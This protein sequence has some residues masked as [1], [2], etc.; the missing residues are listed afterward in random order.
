MKRDIKYLLV[1]LVLFVLTFYF[2]REYPHISKAEIGNIS[3]FKVM[4]DGNIIVSEEGKSYIHKLFRRVKLR[5]E[6]IEKNVKKSKNYYIVRSEE[7]LYGVIDEKLNNILE[8]KFQEILNISFL[9]M[10]IVKINGKYFLYDFL[11]QQKSKG[12]DF[13]TVVPQYKMIKVKNGDKYGVVNRKGKEIFSPQYNEIL[14]FKY[15]KYLVK[16]GDKYGVVDDRNNIIIPIENSEVYFSE[17][18]YLLKKDGKYILNGITVDIP[19][20]YPTLD[21]IVIIDK[22]G[23]FTL[24]DLKNLSLAREIFNEISNE[25]DEYLIVGNGK[26]YSVVNKYHITTGIGYEYDYVE[27]VGK[28]SFKAG[29]LVSGTLKLIVG[30][31]NIIEGD[32]DDFIN[33]FNDEYFLGVIDD[34]LEMID[35]NG[36]I[37]KSV[38]R[39]SVI[40]YDNESLV[41]ENKG[42]IEI[43]RFRK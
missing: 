29:N 22:D 23:G 21:D 20:V 17:K 30:E 9:D 12:Y 15:G 39:R 31:K 42:K 28:N 8:I 43:L 6:V 19:R 1:L 18:N 27:R 16:N 14:A 35:K 7:G 37:L 25:F 13:I 33:I 40:Y 32:Y 2:K 36:K 11:G 24:L 26:G 4:S 5:Y 3:F 34:K 41:T 38:P 10:Y